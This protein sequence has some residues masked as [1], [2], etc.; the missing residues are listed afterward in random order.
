MN[1]SG[2]PITTP[3][4]GVSGNYYVDY[5]IPGGTLTAFKFTHGGSANGADPQGVNLRQMLV[6]GVPL[7]DKNIQDTV[8]DTPMRNYA[9]LESGTNGNLVATNSDIN[10]SYVGIGGT[11]YYYEE[12]GSGNQH[13][14]GAVFK[15][16]NGGVLNFGQQP[17]VGAL[18][19]YDEN[20]G[21]VEVYGDNDAATWSDYVTIVDELSYSA[22]P[23]A[24]FNGVLS[25]DLNQACGGFGSFDDS[26]GLTFD[27]TS[28]GGIQANYSVEL[29]H[30]Q[31]G[32]EGII[33]VNDGQYKT[34]MSPSSKA[35][36]AWSKVNIP[37]SITVNKI[38]FNYRNSDQATSV[39]GVRVDGRL[40]IDQGITAKPDRT[41]ST[42]F[43]TWEQWARTTLGYALDRIAALEQQRKADA[44][45]IAD[46]RTD[47]QA[48]LARIASIE[49]DEV[50]DDAVD[51]VLLATVADLITRI[52]ALENP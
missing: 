4:V 16:Q 39:S 45:T 23:T 9:V 20:T 44:A 52:E 35:Y 51:T 31:N 6:D 43:Q 25:S 33:S 30:F 13:T 10:L 5:D 14:G 50:N 37:S 22:G 1:N 2:S 46:L 29:Y 11:D 19:S 18:K 48:A 17:F 34:I 40:L 8:K 12:D 15:S 3:N 26:K 42:L 21:I 28:I 47:V 7:I 49:S 41:L 36:F 32:S 38:F 24:A 27:F